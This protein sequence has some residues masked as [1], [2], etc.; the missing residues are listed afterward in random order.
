VEPRLLQSESVDTRFELIV[1]SPAAKMRLEDYLLDH[2]A[3]V[4]K[5]YLRELV[6]TERC[7]VNGACENIGY[8]LRAND[9]VEIWIDNTRGTA[10]RP[11]EMPLDILFED[12]DIIVVN[13]PAGM[14][15]HPSHRENGGT[16]LNALVWHFNREVTDGP[17][18]TTIRPGLIHRLDK[19]TS[20]LLVVAKTARAHRIVSAHFMKKRVEKRY[21]ALVEGFVSDDEGTID[22]P[23][24]RFAE[25]KHWSVKEDGKHSRSNYWV[26][27][28]RSDTTLVELEPVTGRTNQLR[29]HC[30]LI[31]HPIVG[32]V[33]RGGRV[34][35][36]LYLHAAKLAF[37]H[38]TTNEMMRFESEPDFPPLI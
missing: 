14:L 6:K 37:P 21:F 18:L 16:L 24:G 7:E 13:K 38:P 5:M 35:S 3:T 8:R 36:R 30:E 4:S 27:E 32:D 22:A 29:I 11:E 25:L 10:M 2:F 23:I 33:K 26:R 34:A 1:P 15:V 19:Q 12:G 31:G 28:R 17:P 9:L 20:G